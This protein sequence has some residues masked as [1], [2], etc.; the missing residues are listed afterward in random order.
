[1]K[2]ALIAQAKEG[3][4]KSVKGLFK[5]GLAQE[6]RLNEEQ[7]AQL[8]YLLMEKMSLLSDQIMVPMMIGE[9]NEADMVASGKAT[10]RAYDEN[11]A[12]IRA[13]LGEEGFNAY[14]RFE[15]TEPERDNMR[16]LTSQFEKTGQK[17]GR[18]HV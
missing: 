13:L 11:V 15:K 5:A 18:A 2:E 14:E 9:V 8:K 7:A 12:K 6:L 16:R 4:E 10:R 17:I 1:M 3:V